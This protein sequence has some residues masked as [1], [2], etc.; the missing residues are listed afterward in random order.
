MSEGN[1]AQTKRVA[2]DARPYKC[3]TIL[4][5]INYPNTTINAYIIMYNY[6]TARVCMHEY[7][8][9]SLTE[10]DIKVK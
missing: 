7:M 4:A 3:A 1:V 9:A 5:A 6:V 8:C 2:A 10:P